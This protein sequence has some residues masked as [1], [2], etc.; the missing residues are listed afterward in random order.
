ME[1]VDWPDRIIL[2][3]QQVEK[4]CYFYFLN[5]LVQQAGLF[6]YPSQKDLG[7]VLLS[8][9]DTEYETPYDK[10]TDKQEQYHRFCFGSLLFLLAVLNR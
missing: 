6:S 9:P 4:T 2:G 5:R 3:Y 7:Q 8:Y 10:A 1:L